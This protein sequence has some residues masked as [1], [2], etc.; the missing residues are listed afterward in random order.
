[1]K[2]AKQIVIAVIFVL[3]I[4]LPAIDS[5]FNFIPDEKSNEN[6]ALKTMPKFDVNLLDLFPEEY[7][8]YYSDNFDLRNQLLWLNSK[9]KFQMF[10]KPPVEGK[11]FIGRDDWM[12]IVKHQMDTY[13]GNNLV[14]DKMLSRYYDIFKYR[15]HFLDSIGCKY[16]VVFAPTK[17]S[18]YPEYLPLSKRK[19]GQRTRTDQMISLLDT[20]KG[21]EVLD[22]RKVLIDAKGATRLYHKTDNHWNEYGSYIA[23]D[24]IM[25]VLSKDFP[26]LE[27]YD[28]TKFKIDST[29][30]D[31][32]ALTNMMGIYEGVTENKISCKPLFETKSKEGIKSN[33]EIPQ[34]FGYETEYERVF[35][36]GND[37]LPK[38]LMIRDSFGRTLMPFLSE[39]FSKSVY[40]FDAWKHEFNEDIVINEKPDIY[41]QLVLE[42]FVH[43]VEITAKMPKQ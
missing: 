27:A 28:I 18:V 12:Y 17:T 33:Y 14:S 36:T 7:D 40:I 2:V 15:Q 37:S 11:A 9:L 41:I 21:L 25:D 26:Q 13:L 19:T 39:H 20:V 10:N 5:L 6:R 32:M 8:E 29:E 43:K 16:Y 31:G 38:L 22:L 30:V 35:V 1:M 42:M 23:Y 24:A 4:T 3:I 34:Y